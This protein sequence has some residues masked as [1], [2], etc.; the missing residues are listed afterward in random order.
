VLLADEE[1]VAQAVGDF[2]E[3]DPDNG[4][5]GAVGLDA[6]AVGQ[7]HR[8]VEARRTAAGR[9]IADRTG[10]PFFQQSARILGE[11]F[12]YAA[13]GAAAGRAGVDRAVRAHDGGELPLVDTQLAGSAHEAA[14]VAKGFGG[15]VAL[16]AVATGVLHK[17]D[18]GAVRLHLKQNQVARAAKE[19]S[20]ALELAGHRVSAFQVQPMVSEG[21]EMLVGV[22][23]DQHFGPVLACGAGGTAT[24]LLKDVAVRITPIT[25]GDADRMVRSLR[26]LPQLDGYRGS[27]RADVDA[28][29]EVLL[30]VSA[31]V[32]AHSEIAEMDLNPLIVH[33]TG[34]TVVDVG[35]RTLMP[36][37]IDAHAHITGLSLTPKNIANP[38]ADIA[39]A[40]AN[41]LRNCLMD[42]Y[43]TIREAGGADHATARLLAEP[44]RRHD[45]TSRDAARVR[46]RRLFPTT[47]TQTLQRVMH[48][49]ILGPV[50]RGEE[51]TP[52]SVLFGL[53]KRA[54]WLSVIPA[55]IVGVGIRPE[56]APDFARRPISVA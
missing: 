50:L 27:P 40:S 54:P 33:P 38:A 37:L 52:P 14:R 34:A 17:S 6:R 25:K 16:K 56:H 1:G 8:V 41:Y 30:R 39:I 13:C 49:R 10:R 24:E 12:V 53:V 36:G 4:P 19:M 45:V 21:V 28:L 35:G 55:Y 18:A 11:R 32:E 26:T 48:A 23:Q 29:E 47:V 5:E 22:V 15:E 44:L 31:L 43:T 2:R 51:A 7:L 3:A 42:G 20:N 46:R 9:V